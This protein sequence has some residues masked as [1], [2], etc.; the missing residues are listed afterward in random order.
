MARKA[1]VLVI[2]AL[3]SLS[4]VGMPLHYHYCKGQLK[5]VTVFVK[6]ECHGEGTTQDA[7]TCCGVQKAHCST[8]HSANQCCDDA[9]EWLQEDIPGVSAKN[10]TQDPDQVS[11]AVTGLVLPA[12]P[13]VLGQHLTIKADTGP[14]LSPIPLFLSHCSLIFY[15]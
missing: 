12:A 5:H 7:H 13:T 10:V 1:L 8:G 6:L 15:G 11:D 14:P 9:T 2:V 3:Y 4:V